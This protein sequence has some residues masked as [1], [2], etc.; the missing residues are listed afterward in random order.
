MDPL[1]RERL[2]TAISKFPYW[3]LEE[4]SRKLS[5]FNTRTASDFFIMDHNKLISNFPEKSIEEKSE[6]S[7]DSYDRNTYEFK[8]V[9]T[10]AYSEKKHEL[11][12]TGNVPSIGMSEVKVLGRQENWE[13]KEKLEMVSEHGK[14]V[15]KKEKEIG[16]N[17]EIVGKVREEFSLEGEIATAERKERKNG[18][19]G[20]NSEK[21]CDV[22]DRELMK[23]TGKLHEKPFFPNDT[24][25]KS[26]ENL[27]KPVV[28]K[29]EILRENSLITP[30]NFEKASIEK[31]EVPSE[32]SLRNSKILDKSSIEIAETPKENSLKSTENLEKPSI[33]IAEVQIEISLKTT[34]NLDEKNLEENKAPEVNS[35]QTTE[36]FE[37]TNIEDA[38]VPQEKD[39]KTTEN[40]DKK[41]VEK[42]P[43]EKIL[44]PTEKVDKSS[45]EKPILL[46]ESLTSE[47]NIESQNTDGNEMP[48]NKPVQKSEKASIPAENIEKAPHSNDKE[49]SH[50]ATPPLFVD[51]TSILSKKDD[52]KEGCC[53]KCLL[54]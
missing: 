14:I 9:P 12:Y 7:E 29:T 20:G 8:K 48:S 50:Y 38:E 39:L 35:L 34:E 54:L 40:L 5:E 46:T 21:I 30:G 6:S 26:T 51:K 52:E 19:E 4:K 18:E 28:E 45:M 16:K 23:E 36:I 49:P 27:E 11:V 10:T 53:S 44:E 1:L 47:K 37:N 17:Q 3:D 31:K 13:N 24:T 22:P 43:K 33:E 2:R 32:K 25:L 15:E 42:A 41:N